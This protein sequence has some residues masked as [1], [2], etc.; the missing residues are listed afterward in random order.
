MANPG[1]TLAEDAALKRRLS[2]LSVSDDRTAVRVPKVFFRYPE[3]ETENEYPFITIDLLDIAYAPQRQESERTYY[4]NGSG[5]GVATNLYFY[6][7]EMDEAAMAAQ[8]DGGVLTTDQFV[9]VDLVY[10][11]TTHCRSQRHDR[12][13]TMLILRRVFPLRRG[14]IEVPEDGT[15]RRCDLMDWRNTDVLDQEAAYRKHI[16]RKAY[17]VVINAEIPQSDLLGA[18]QVT[19]VHGSLTAND[20]NLPHSFTEDF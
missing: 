4:Y 18:L 20:P 16:F 9:P 7:S 13:L 1:L 6:P 11:V 2:N 17:T 8:A 10:Q 5:D 14:F 12:Q 15:V 19:E 3:G